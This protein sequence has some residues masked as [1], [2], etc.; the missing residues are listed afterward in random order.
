M[1]VLEDVPLEGGVTYYL[2]IDGWNGA[3]GDYVLNIVEYEPCVLEC[4]PGGTPEGEPP[5]VDDYEDAYNGG[6]NS[7]EYGIPFQELYG[8]ANGDLVFC[9]VA[10]WYVYDGANYRD[11]DWF[12]LYAGP[13]GTVEV[14]AH[15]E[16]SS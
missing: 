14:T 13:T 11:T 16:R 4:P 15:A 10:G 9:G 1:S 6:C 2:V 3:H 5:L 7:P 12:H 8:D